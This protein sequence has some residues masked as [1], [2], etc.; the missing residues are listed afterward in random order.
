GD[1]TVKIY[2][3]EDS[4]GNDDS[5]FHEHPTKLTITNT[6]ADTAAPVLSEFDFTPK[7]VDLDNDYPTVTVTAR[8]TDATGADAPILSLVSRTTGQTL[9]IGRMRRTSG[10]TTDGYYRSSVTVYTIP[11]GA[12]DI[13]IGPLRD[14]L[15][16]TGVATIHAEALKLSG[17]DIAAPMMSDFDFTPKTLDLANG[18]QTVTV[19]AR[20]TD[21]SGVVPPYV[22]L[23]LDK[24]G[25][26]SPDNGTMT[27]IS[28]DARD[29]VYQRQFTVPE[30]APVG[31]WS[32]G[33]NPL[34]DIL[35]NHDSTFHHN[36]TSLVVTNRLPDTA[37]PV[38]SDFDFSPKTLDLDEGPQAVTF[39]AHITDATGAV[40]PILRLV[41]DETGQT[42]HFGQMDYSSGLATDA[43]YRRTIVIPVTASTGTWTATITPLRD[44]L[45]NHD[46]TYHNH[47]TKLTVLKTSSDTASPILSEFDFT[48]K[49][50]D[51][52]GSSREV[53]VT[54]R[55][56]DATGALAP[57]LIL[58]S[59]DT[60]QTLGFGE[61]T[62]I[63]GTAQDGIYQGTVT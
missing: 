4:L 62:R 59:D 34:Q 28:G 43:R 11:T 38:L 22:T 6:P 26:Q 50:L 14:A 35:G 30:N 10:T 36:P 47:P 60:T 57:T 15:G 16:N 2:P 33:I 63:S 54:A 17:N 20:V 42:L 18:P 21:N 45:G 25:Q 13:H 61:M 32:F 56:T 53:V 5:T 27:L 52:A 58:S 39:T 19:R 31:T 23:Q 3:L 12:W 40:T 29:G 51:V 55:V 49:T 7:A 24:G 46:A 44:T 9:E 41:S 1:W 37:A 48:P 8:I